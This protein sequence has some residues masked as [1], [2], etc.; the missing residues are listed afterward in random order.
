M[1]SGIKNWNDDGLMRNVSKEL[2][3]RMKKALLSSERFTKVLVSRGNIGGGNPSKPF[4]PPKV[5]T[6]VLRSAIGFQIRKEGFTVIGVLGVRKG[7]A[8][9]YA[10]RLE[11]GF[12]GR[13]SLGRVYNQKPR[14]YLVPTLTQHG[15]TILNIIRR[16]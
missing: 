8:D 11:K 14:P 9:D 5:V 12:V 3:K 16:G 1:S 15:P 7:P 4:E 13:D 2:E 6:G 10:I